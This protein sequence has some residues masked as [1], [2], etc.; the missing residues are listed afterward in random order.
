MFPHSKIATELIFGRFEREP[1]YHPKRKSGQTDV[2]S[3]ESLDRRRRIRGL[4]PRR[5]GLIAWYSAK[6]APIRFPIVFAPTLFGS[7][8]A[9]YAA[10]TWPLWPMNTICRPASGTRA[11][12]SCFMRISSSSSIRSAQNYI[13]WGAAEQRQP[14]SGYTRRE[15]GATVVLSAQKLVPLLSH[16]TTEFHLRKKVDLQATLFL[17]Q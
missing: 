1:Q 10:S 9:G 12:F 7:E 16:A 17:I 8:A 15:S 4:C 13:P 2:K 5:A 3:G 14:A 6:S 11:P